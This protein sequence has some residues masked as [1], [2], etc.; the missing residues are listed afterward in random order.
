MKKRILLFTAVIGIA[1][2][3]LS[4]YRTGAANNGYDA[5]NNG[6]NTNVLASCGPGGCH[7]SGAGPTV[8]VTL[9][10]AGTTVTKYKA[11]KTYTIHINGT[12]TSNSYFGFQVCVLKGTGT[13]QTDAGTLATAVTGTRLVAPAPPYTPVTIVEQ[14]AAIAGSVGS[15]ATTATWTAPAT[16]GTGTVTIYATLNSV[17]HNGSNNSL[18]VSTNKIVTFAEETAVSSVPSISENV[19]IKAYPNPCSNQFRLQLNN[20]DAGTYTVKAYDM[21]GRC[22]MNESVEVN[23]NSYETS[24][25]TSNWA[26]GFYGVQIIKDGAQRVIPIIKQ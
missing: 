20:A 3:S 16:A 26:P 11:G 12:G 23:S 19:A 22:L 13:A 4:S 17:D 6:V 25:N 18:D 24:I 21:G 2:L 5:T 7:G 9:D 10:S 8:T 1:Y 14:S 15:F